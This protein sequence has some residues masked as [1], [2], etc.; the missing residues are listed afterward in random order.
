[1]TGDKLQRRSDLN[2]AVLNVVAGLYYP[3]VFVEERTGEYK[4]RDVTTI[5]NLADRLNMTLNWIP[6]PDDILM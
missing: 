4:G 2:G 1:M 6:N 3:W 5:R